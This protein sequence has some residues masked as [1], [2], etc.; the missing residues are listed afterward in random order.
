MAAK[1]VDKWSF[2]SIPIIPY[3]F[4]MSLGTAS[5]FTVRLPSGRRYLITNYHVVSGKRPDSGIVLRK[6]GHVPDRMLMALPQFEQ[7]VPTL[8]WQPHVQLL[9][10]KDFRHAWIEHPD[11]G[12]AFDVVALPLSNLNDGQG[13][14]IDAREGEDVGLF[15]GST[16]S[17]IGFPYGLSGPFLSA[18]WKTGAIASEPNLPVNDQDFFWV[19]ANSRPG[20]SG[21]PVIARRLGSYI[22]S[23]GNTCIATSPVDRLL[24]VYAGRALDAADMTMGR[25]WRWGGVEKIL[26][27]AESQLEDGSLRAYPATIGHFSETD[28]PTIRNRQADFQNANGIMEMI[29][30]AKL[31]PFVASLD[32][33]FRGSLEMLKTQAAIVA[34]CNAATDTIEIKAPVAAILAECLRVPQGW[35]YPPGYVQIVEL[36]EKTVEEL[37]AIGKST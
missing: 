21:S 13:Y 19:D 35:A 5:G 6:D 2:A 3:S 15:P 37:E 18:I 12:C 31:L 30:V 23:D 36:I 27:L 4:S 8:R 17:I 10:D 33:R 24:G 28:M 34:T 14:Y 7:D 29:T 32:I 9:I 25:V 20:M 11:Y 22:T 16:V 1:L 26:K